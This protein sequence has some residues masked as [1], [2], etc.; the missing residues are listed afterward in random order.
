MKKILLIATILAQTITSSIAQEM[1]WF[2]GHQKEPSYKG[3]VKEIKEYHQ[4]G[5]RRNKITLTPN[6]KYYE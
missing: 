5:N 4:T 2:M 1:P 3:P 6:N